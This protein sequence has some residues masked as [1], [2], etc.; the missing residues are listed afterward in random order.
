MLEAQALAVSEVLRAR[1]QDV[2]D[3]VQPVVP[4]AAV[5]GQVLLDPA[6]DLIDD[7][8]GE[9]DDMERVEHGAG[10]VEL[11]VDGV[12]VT[13]ER[14][15]GGDLDPLSDRLAPLAQPGLVR[16]PRAAGDQVQ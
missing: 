4:A 11:V 5:A 6:P 7:P 3:P 12:L 1:A 15:Q 14:V 16:L 13:V 10:V 8:G 9:L 2:A